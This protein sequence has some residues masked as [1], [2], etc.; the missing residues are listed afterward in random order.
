MVQDCA[1][2]SR[3]PVQVDDRKPLALHTDIVSDG[4]EAQIHAGLTANA[5]HVKVRPGELADQ[6]FLAIQFNEPGMVGWRIRLIQ[7]RAGEWI[8]DLEGSPG[9]L[10]GN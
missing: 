8:P 3:P 1:Q 7:E 10:G 5:I 4:F 2:K 9:V 6:E